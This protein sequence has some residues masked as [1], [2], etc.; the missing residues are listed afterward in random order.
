M[1]YGLYCPIGNGS[2]ERKDMVSGE[3]LGQL[4]EW[5]WDRE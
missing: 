4:A 2:G 1:Y 3:D 5:S